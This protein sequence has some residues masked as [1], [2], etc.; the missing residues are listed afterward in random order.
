MYALATMPALTFRAKLLA[1]HLLLVTAV[2]MLVVLELNRTLG[3]DLARQLDDRLE[4]QAK[5]ASQ[6][7][8]DGRR[9]PD[10]LA[11]RLALVVNA[12]EDDLRP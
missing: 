4:Q 1:S 9:H 10:K 6:W 8:G 5:G 12:E 2:V 3:G 7:V 11:S